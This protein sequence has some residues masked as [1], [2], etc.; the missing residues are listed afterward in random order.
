[1]GGSSSEWCDD[2]NNSWNALLGGGSPIQ[3]VDRDVAIIDA[4]AGTPSVTSYV[5]TVGTLNFGIAVNPSTGRLYVS[6]TDARNQVRFERGLEILGDAQGDED[7]ICDDNEATSLCLPAL[8]GHLVDTRVTVTTGTTVNGT[9]NLNPHIIFDNVAI[10]SI[11]KALSLGQPNGMAF[12][13]AG[14]TLYAAAILSKK[15]AK[16]DTSAVPGTLTTRIDVGEGPTGVALLESKS[17]L[18]VMNRHENTISVVNTGTDTEILPRVLLF[19]P[20]PAVIKNGRKFLYD[21]QLTSG[22]GDISCAT[23]HAFGDFDLLSWDLGDPQKTAPFDARP[24]QSP[25]G[26]APLTECGSNADCVGN[27]NPYPCCT[28]P[29][30]GTCPN[31][32]GCGPFHPIKGPRTTQ[33]LRGLTGTEPFHWHGDRANFNAYNV[34]FPGLLRKDSQLTTGS[35]QA[36]TDFMNTVVFPPNPNRNLDDTLTAAGSAGQNEFL[37]M[38]RDSPFQCVSCHGLPAGTNGKFINTQADQSSQAMKV[39]HL[40]NMHEKTGLA[41]SPNIL[42]AVPAETRNGFGFTHDGEVDTLVTFLNVPVFSFGGNMTAINNT[43]AFMDQFDSGQAVTVGH[44]IT[45]D[46]TN[47]GDPGFNTLLAALNQGKI[48]LVVKGVFGGVPRTFRCT[49]VSPTQATCQPDRV[50]E[51]AIDAAALRDSSGSGSELTFWAVPVGFGQRMGLDR[52][53]DA[54]YDHDELDAG[55]DPADAA[56]TPAMSAVPA[57]S[58]WGFGLFA[59]TLALIYRRRIGRRQI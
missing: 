44:Q 13:N 57:L 27:Q 29:G 2:N 43:I 17:R 42:V 59:A 6:N 4:D 55:S 23:C 47:N 56:S 39:P 31:Q 8:N 33:T 1:M 14:T 24:P 50:G 30:A 7:G 26:G 18:Y 32:A 20:E 49:T 48:D 19:N 15:V 10:S 28:G 25:P 53:G 21:G 45:F 54:F 35:M 58:G 40:R 41:L 36:F 11:N 9:V 5:T 52:D 51:S 22:R 16:I 38:T 12:N 46:G 3:M 34:A 37:N